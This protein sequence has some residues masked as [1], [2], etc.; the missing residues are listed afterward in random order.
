M[1]RLNLILSLIVVTLL[2]NAV[3]ARAA[4]DTF[5]AEVDADGSIAGGGSGFGL[6]GGVWWY[7]QNTDWWNQWFEN[8]P[9]DPDRW[10]E[11][12]VAFEIFRLDPGAGDAWAEVTLNWST[13]VY[14]DILSSPMNPPI[15]PLTPEQEDLFIERAEPSLFEGQVGDM[16]TQDV[17]PPIH[18]VIDDYNPQWVSIDIHGYN[19]RIDGRID[20]RCVPEPA[21]LSLLGLGGMAM[22]RRRRP[23]T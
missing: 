2:V 5:W 13:P 11:I 6:G 17:D 9:F 1:T 16:T 23:V 22:V 3:P 8:T 18:Y 19:F 14:A 10:K 20:H 4:L 21:S 7:Y 15:P 12:D